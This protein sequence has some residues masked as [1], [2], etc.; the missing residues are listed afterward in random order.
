MT[1]NRYETCKFGQHAECHNCACRSCTLRIEASAQNVELSLESPRLAR[2]R[3]GIGQKI[4]SSNRIEQ[5]LGLRRHFFDPLFEKFFL[6]DTRI[7]P[8]INLHHLQHFYSTKYCIR[9]AALFCSAKA[10]LN[11]ARVIVLHGGRWQSSS[12][13]STPHPPVSL[14]QNSKHLV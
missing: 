4:R 9:R 11:E 10:L 2:V 6:L 13:C 12:D 5:K 7:Y 1:L 8:A 3:G 14:L